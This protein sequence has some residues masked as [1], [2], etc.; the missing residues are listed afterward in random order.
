[1]LS[2]ARVYHC[3]SHELVRPQHVVLPRLE[4][5]TRDLEREVRA[6]HVRQRIAD[7]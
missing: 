1:M 7:P 3:A 2:M 4:D 5:G 6:A